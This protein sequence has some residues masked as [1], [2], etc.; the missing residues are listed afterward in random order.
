MAIVLLK[1]S[2]EECSVLAYRPTAGKSENIVAEDRLEDAVQPVEIGNRIKPLRLEPPQQSAV[3]VVRAG[4]GDDF[5]HA[6]GRAPELYSE[7][8]GLS[9]DFLDGLRDR[10]HLLLAG[11]RDI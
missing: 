10:E 11:T 9:R 5:K 4:S 3:K 8:A 7:I 6:A 1:S 2:E